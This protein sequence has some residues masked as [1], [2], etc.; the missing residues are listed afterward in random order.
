MA[1]VTGMRVLFVGV[2]AVVLATVIYGFTVAGSPAGE[3]AKRLDQQKADTM[4]QV[5]FA[6]DGWYS[7]HG[8]LPASLGADL[9]SG[10]DPSVLG[11]IEYLPGDKGDYRLC[12]TFSAPT[13]ES[14]VGPAPVYPM[15]Q[16]LDRSFRHGS[17]HQCFDLHVSSVGVA[18]KP[19]AGCSLMNDPST[20]KVDC[21]G[22]SGTGCK[23]APAGWVPFE[24]DGPVGVPYSCF[25]SDSGCELAQ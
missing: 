16:A 21:F 10:T 6:L 20:G 25:A 24:P 12:A 4:N 2:V 15:P 9:V 13:D 1:K 8:S 11:A 23:A 3:R 14:Q 5:S 22:C 7:A 18:G 19:V 17:G